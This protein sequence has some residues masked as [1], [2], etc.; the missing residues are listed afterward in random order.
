M[1]LL[2]DNELKWSPI[3]A[4]SRM[5]R[6]RIASGVNSYEQEI[7]F[8]PEQ[9]VYDRIKRNGS[10]SWLDICCGK[11]NAL[12]QAAK[13][14][15]TTMRDGNATLVGIDIIDDFSEIPRVLPV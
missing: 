15:T 13:F 12:I 1:K 7:G 5:N 3:V 9:F 2:S 4:N 8:I 10:V 14:L 11:G 6:Q